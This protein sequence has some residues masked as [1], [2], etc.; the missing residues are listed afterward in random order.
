MNGRPHI[1]A[2]EQARE[3]IGHGDLLL[4]RANAHNVISRVIS[5]FGRSIYCHAARAARIRGELRCLEVREWHGARDVSLY[6]QVK[7]YPARWDVFLANPRHLGSSVAEALEREYDARKAVEFLRGL[8]GR[9]YGW[10]NLLRIAGLHVPMLRV[11]IRPPIDDD[12][13]THLLPVCSHAQALADRMAGVDPVPNLTD[14][15]TEPADL[16]RSLF[17]RYRFTLEP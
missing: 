4:L 6:D 7:Q 15:V 9:P 14:R 16:A 12:A 11:L 3:L 10:A 2:W 13:S 8:I 5:R 17:Y 1:V